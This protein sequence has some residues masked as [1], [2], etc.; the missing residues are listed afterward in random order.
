MKKL[1][2]FVLIL[3][4]TIFVFACANQEDETPAFDYENDV[5]DFRNFQSENGEHKDSVRWGE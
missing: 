4:G 3:V 5:E 2:A 1:M